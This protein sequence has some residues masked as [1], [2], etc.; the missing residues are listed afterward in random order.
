MNFENMNFEN[1]D[2]KNGPVDRIKK[3][4]ELKDSYLDYENLNMALVEYA[5]SN[6]EIN[7]INFIESLIAT[8]A[9]S[10]QTN[11]G[12]LDSH[13]DQVLRGEVSLEPNK[14]MLVVIKP[15][16]GSGKGTLS[17][18][19]VVELKD[20]LRAP[21]MER[22]V[23]ILAQKID[24]FNPGGKFQFSKFFLP[25]VIRDFKD[26]SSIGESSVRP[27]YFGNALDNFEDDFKNELA[28]KI[29]DDQDVMQ[30]IAFFDG[31]VGNLDRKDGN[32]LVGFKN[33]SELNSMENLSSNIK[34]I[35]H[36]L[37]LVPDHIASRFH[38]RGPRLAV[39]Y[40]NISEDN[41][42][43]AKNRHR[44]LPEELKNILK[45]LLD[46][47]NWDELQKALDGVLNEEELKLFR[48]RVE[49]FYN[50]GY[51]I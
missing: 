31:L 50:K 44:L 39:G 30:L 15:V 48:E 27:F 18:N 29:F 7:N 12:E 34:L 17:K 32:I 1:S 45:S 43:K 20:P 38:F 6:G 26:N 35:D 8:N 16:N 46:E 33:E 10:D 41:F 2:I 51:F 37:I 19:K 14:K 11:V 13:Q 22:F 3:I 49:D 25:V 9:H 36:T 28:D 24:Q 4:N 23:W 21:S 5:L 40:D 42:G 47:N